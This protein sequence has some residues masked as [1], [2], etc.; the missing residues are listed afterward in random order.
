MVCSQI[1]KNSLNIWN[2][3]HLVVQTGLLFFQFL[4]LCNLFC[5]SLVQ[6]IIALF[7]LEITLQFGEKTG[8]ILVIVNFKQWS[9]TETISCYLVKEFIVWQ[10]CIFFQTAPK[11]V[12]KGLNVKCTS[13]LL[14]KLAPYYV[15][16]STVIK[17]S[18]LKKI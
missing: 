17:T 1:K 4:H 13:S 15:Y 10:R 18:T 8:K 3:P 11:P 7:Q 12:S 9:F 6:H 5:F 14:W 16:R 2:L